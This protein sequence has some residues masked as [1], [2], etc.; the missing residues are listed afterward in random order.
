MF[1]KKKEGKPKIGYCFLCSQSIEGNYLSKHYEEH[2]I[3]VT[4]TDGQSA[5]TFECP[6]C[7]AMDRAWGGRSLNDNAARSS[8]ASAIALHLHDR[9]FIPLD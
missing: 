5:Y 2:L 7:G 3:P 8:A 9:H 1:G 6:K 4:D